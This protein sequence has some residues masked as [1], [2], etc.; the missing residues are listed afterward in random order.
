MY[1]NQR[2]WL[3]YVML[4]QMTNVSLHFDRIWALLPQ[5]EAITL[6][7]HINRCFLSITF[8]CHHNKVPSKGYHQNNPKNKRDSST[9]KTKNCRPAV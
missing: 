2:V 1:T 6:N 5:S 7:K 3:N 8:N 4:S 9:F